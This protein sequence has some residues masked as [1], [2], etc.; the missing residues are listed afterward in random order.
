MTGRRHSS[1]FLSSAILESK[2]SETQNVKPLK[3]MCILSALETRRR[4]HEQV[5]TL[6]TATVIGHCF[7]IISQ[8]S[9]LTE[10]QHSGENLKEVALFEECTY[11][12]KRTER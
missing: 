11:A 1:I 7:K 4:R 2:I 9:N 5:N 8:M 3:Q 12:I 10:K 6:T